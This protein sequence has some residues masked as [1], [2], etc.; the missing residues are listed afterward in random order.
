MPAVVA[1]IAV[2]LIVLFAHLAEG[3]ALAKASCVM[4]KTLAVPV[5]LMVVLTFVWNMQGGQSGGFQPFSDMVDSASQLVQLFGPLVTYTRAEVWLAR[6]LALAL[7]VTSVLVVIDSGARPAIPWP[8]R[9][10]RGHLAA[11]LRPCPWLCRRTAATV[12]AMSTSAYPFSPQYFLLSGSALNYRTCVAG[13]APL[14]G[15]RP[16]LRQW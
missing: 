12:P 9:R 14:G 4:I 8:V 5:G 15:E 10:N 16:P 3:E 7:I 11:T 6:L 13:R 1:T 2:V